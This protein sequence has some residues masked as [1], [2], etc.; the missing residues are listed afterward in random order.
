MKSIEKTKY[1]LG[2]RMIARRCPLYSLKIIRMATICQSLKMSLIY[3]LEL[4][5][6]HQ[7]ALKI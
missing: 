3:T 2:E 7:I 4:T 6:C 5:K 1:I